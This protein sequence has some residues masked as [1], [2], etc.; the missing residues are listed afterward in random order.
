ME[1]KILLVPAIYLLI[2]AVCFASDMY[3]F[4]NHKKN[5]EDLEYNN[6]GIIFMHFLIVR[7]NN[8]QNIVHVYDYIIIMYVCIILTVYHLCTYVY[9]YIISMYCIVYLC[10]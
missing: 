10:I 2:S 9:T 4:I 1:K 3:F 7:I 5:L 8:H 6:G